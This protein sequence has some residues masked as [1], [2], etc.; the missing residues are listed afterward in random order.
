M[1]LFWLGH[2]R[3]WGYSQSNLLTACYDKGKPNGDYG[4]IDPTVDT[5]YSF[6]KTF[7]K[8]LATVFPDKYLHLGG[9]EVPFGC[10]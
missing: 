6:L 8:E 10:W 2:S 1:V 4:P 5:T 9:D 7:M 3:S